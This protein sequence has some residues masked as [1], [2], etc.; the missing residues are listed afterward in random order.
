MQRIVFRSDAEQIEPGGDTDSAAAVTAT[1]RVTLV[2]PATRAEYERALAG[3]E[4]I[5]HHGDETLPGRVPAAPTEGAAYVAT[6]DTQRR[7]WSLPDIADASR[8]GERPAVAVMA[9]RDAIRTLLGGAAHGQDSRRE[10]ELRQAGAEAEV[11]GAQP[12]VTDIVNLKE[13]RGRI[14]PGSRQAFDALSRST[15]LDAARGKLGAAI[16]LLERKT[17]PALEQS[18]RTLATLSQRPITRQRQ[19]EACETDPLLDPDERLAGVCWAVRRR[20][21]RAER[22]LAPLTSSA[23]AEVEP[24]PAEV[25]R[26]LRACDRD[27]I[28]TKRLDE[29]IEQL[30]AALPAWG[31]AVSRV[32][33][34]LCRL[35][36]IRRAL[37]EGG[38]DDA[39]LRTLQSLVR[40][41]DAVRGSLEHTEALEDDLAAARSAIEAVEKHWA[42]AGSLAA[43][44]RELLGRIEAADLPV[45]VLDEAL[46]E[47]RR[48]L[49]ATYETAATSL[50]RVRLLT[51]LPWVRRAPERVELARA[52][53]GLDASHAGCRQVKDRI[54]RFLAVRTLH[55]T[56]WTVE[57][58]RAAE[59]GGGSRGPA[60]IV[61]RPPRPAAPSPILCFAGP[62]GCGKTSLAK[63]IGQ[64][65]GRPCVRV[66]LGGVWDEAHV[67][68]LPPSFRAPGPGLIVQG[69]AEAGVR[70]PVVIL[71][72]IDK[73][74]RRTSN[75]GN[76]AAALLEVLD[77]AQ[78]SAF[79]DRYAGLPVDLAE[80]LW[81]G[82]A[83]D[84]AAMPAPLRDRMDVIE[85][86]GYTDEEKLAIVKRHLERIVEGSGLA[87]ERLWTDGSGLTPRGQT[88]AGP[89]G[90]AAPSALV[91]ETVDREAASRE[92]PDPEAPGPSLP[93]EMSDAAI[94]AVIRGHT[95]EAGVRHLLR[96]VGAVCEE[97]ACRRVAAGDTAPVLIVAHEGERAG[98]PATRRLTV[99][100]VLGP[101]Q[102]E[103]LP[104]QVRDVVAR[105]QERVMGLPRAD[106]EAASA[107][108]WIEVVTDLPWNRRAARVDGS[109]VK[110]ALDRAH[111]GCEEQKQ[112][113]LDHLA[114]GNADGAPAAGGELP[115]LVGPSGVGKTALARSLAAALGRGFVEVPLAGARDAAAIRGI[116]RPRPD[117]APGRL[118]AAL[119][120]LGAPAER[121]TADP[122]VVLDRLD[123]LADGPAADA[124]LDAL[125]PVRNHA[126]RD[127]Y[128]GLPIDLSAVTWLATAA[129]PE[130]VPGTL[131][132]RLDVIALPGYCEAEKLRIAV[133]HVVPQRLA[134]HGLTPERLSFS[135]A[136][137]RRLIRGYTREAGVKHLDR[138]VG[139][140]TRR[141]A[142]L[143][144]EDGRWPGEVGPE[145]LGAAIAEP[146]FREG[147]F[148]DRTRRPGVAVGLG[149]S[150]AGGRL[151]FVEARCLPGRGA[152]RVTGTLGTTMRESA[153]VALTWVREHAHRLDALFTAF[154]WT[155]IH[156]HLPA[157]GRRQDGPS[158][159]VTIVT[160]VVS[161][162]TGKAVR[163]GVAMTGEI[164]LSG[165]VLRVG[166][167]EEKLLA[168]E[169]CGV[170]NVIVPAA[171]RAD[172][173]SVG[174]ELR[175]EITIHY[176]ETI[177]DV[178]TVALPGALRDMAG[179][180]A[181]KVRMVTRQSS[182]P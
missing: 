139:D 116:A 35:A 48:S 80:V 62:P 77:P 113:L 124:L 44:T 20:F 88:D 126:F 21:D 121:R 34:R 14:P 95:C 49:T 98:A 94:R 32:I 10:G 119:R 83:N 159:G 74:G 87:V 45:R 115:C 182:A 156:V 149:V 153:S 33:D 31:H 1:R 146:P 172:V 26:S 76:P 54:R 93:V 127:H 19:S 101:S 86:P 104:E 143:G 131:R 40:D 92:G 57:A 66:P 163:A 167:V 52:M 27:A 36:I 148:A 81:I 130:R 162:L 109:A 42:S 134:R 39:S 37:Q 158:A 51:R 7:A 100:Q 112:R 174:E 29:V 168:A 75:V 111:T 55:G 46:H 13:G 171:N 59:P 11:G 84:L 175:R 41:I 58:C 8:E 155:D 129:D 164:T 2:F 179:D 133:E 177:D 63:V 9:P 125:D 135:P 89:V 61:V 145:A 161:V 79:V 56:A 144:R 90:V 122:V 47:V 120:Q 73:V 176:A 152:V 132:D 118:V 105:E 17:L 60:A 3:I 68:G 181:P 70:N 64:A 157:G 117:A 108:D 166:S 72:E 154:D 30:G 53:A 103:A 169:R 180:G 15:Q 147:E 38:W 78:N 150:P 71:D 85:V 65:L 4:A 170:A 24:K 25:R 28:D 123:Q 12:P 23:L 97:V 43:E 102:Q 160:A 16:E 142:R 96:L 128:I 82:T 91:V 140:F 110:P 69:L 50:D 5:V 6:T 178:L 141:V 22:A 138:L 136:A 106:P 99:E 151:V 18:H 114:A 173:M 165:D 137:I 67:R 107:I